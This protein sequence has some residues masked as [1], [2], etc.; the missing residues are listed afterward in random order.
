MD[1]QSCASCHTPGSHFTDNQVHDI[2]SAGD[3]A[4]SGFSGA[5]DTPTLL[6]IAH[7]APYFHD[8]RFLTLAQVVS[9]FDE[10]FSLDLGKDGRAD[11]TA[12][13]EAVGEGEEP[14]QRFDDEATPF[15]LMIE[16]LSV[17]LSTLDTLIPERDLENADLLLRTVA[18]DME[19]DA[20]AMTNRDARDKTTELAETLWRLRDL[21]RR[22]AWDEADQAW[23]SY[24]AIADAYD[25]ELR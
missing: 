25:S 14:Y 8:G 20:S 2:G 15:R 13:L 21:I 12:Y 1:G 16:E 5:M 18:N 17:F 7:T 9:W 19:L 6:G 11:L 10:L 24:R 22:A 23:Q 4:R 3:G